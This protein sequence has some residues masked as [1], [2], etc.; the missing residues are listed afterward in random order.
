MLVTPLTFALINEVYRGHLS[1]ARGHAAVLALVRLG[2]AVLAL[3]PATV[4][5]GATFPALTRQLT[6]SSALSQAFGRL[7]CANTWARSSGRWSRASS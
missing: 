2:L 6:R 1:G 5:M 4:M 7:Y 3:A